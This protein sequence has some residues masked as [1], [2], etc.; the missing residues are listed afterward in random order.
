MFA[1][2]I[3]SC[4]KSSNTNNIL[5][6]YSND[7]IAFDK[8]NKEVVTNA[9]RL[10][11]ETSEKKIEQINSIEASKRTFVNTA[12]A[13]DEL[14]SD[15]DNLLA[16]L[17]LIGNA[18]E[19]DSTRITA[20]TEFESLSLYE[21]NIYLNESL[22]KSLQECLT[23]VGFSNL[24]ANEQKFLTDNITVF[25]KNGMKLDYSGREYIKYTNEKLA[26]LESSFDRNINDYNDSIEFAENELKGIP[27][28]LLEEWK[29]GTGK[30][31]VV[32][33]EPNC[34]VILTFA[35]NEKTRQTIYLKHNNR[36]YPANIKVLD[37]L[38][39]YR[40]ELA[41][42]LGFKSY[43][44]YTITD[45]MAKNPNNVW[46]FLG[47][48][49]NKLTP[50]AKNDLLAYTKLKHLDNSRLTDQINPWD[51]SYYKN[52]YSETNYQINEDSLKQYFEMGNVLKGM[53]TIYEN[54]FDITI[55]ESTNN[56]LWSSKVKAYELFNNGKLSGRFYLDLYPRSSKYKWFACFP[57][58]T[59]QHKDQMERLPAA[60]LLCNF[61]EGYNGNPTLLSHNDVTT[62]FHEFGHLVYKLLSRTEI[63]TQD[64]SYIKDDFAEAPSQFLENWCWQYESLKIFAKHYKTGKVLSKEL[65]DKIILSQRVGYAYKQLRR[66]ESSMLDLTYYDKYD[67]IKNIDISKVAVEMSKKSLLP[68]TENVHSICSWNHLN[69][70]GA[71]YYG[72]LWSEVFAADLFSEFKKNGIMDKE[73][74]IKYK[75]E[76]LEKA[77]SK[78][79]IDM[80]RRFLNREPNSKA[81]YEDLN[82]SK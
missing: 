46:T 31:T 22:Y 57:I 5:L 43:A 58:S 48:L 3:F 36:A 70:Y 66:V 16:K 78:N 4:S 67:S 79:E 8:I 74:G 68:I 54:L 72:Y 9:T 65:F 73:T 47:D 14:I 37:S 55:K 1:C 77:A 27:K 11:F 45:K 38:F 34:N 23:Q 49:K 80:M 82:I 64:E 35:S 52:R 69:G 53:F 29:H 26:E 33:N 62:L 25:E 76:I 20:L 42:T 17:Q 75:K 10:I 39:F 18:F 32:L 7:P 6:S 2:M 60:A 15:I 30:Y 12:I 40:N 81:F 44:A 63:A 19:D 50:A 13:F 51:V 41:K 21:S 61:Q 24:K 56:Q 59:Y 71:N 28:D